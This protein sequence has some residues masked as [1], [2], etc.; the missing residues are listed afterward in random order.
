MTKDLGVE[1]DRDAGQGGGER[2]EAEVRPV[3]LGVFV[4]ALDD[5]RPDDCVGA[6]SRGTSLGIESGLGEP[7]LDRLDLDASLAVDADGP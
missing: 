6:A 7:G 5:V 3:Q 1:D 4:G 2:H